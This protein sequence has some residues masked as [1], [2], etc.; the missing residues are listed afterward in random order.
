M[1]SLSGLIL[2]AH[3]RLGLN[4]PDGP[5]WQPRSPQVRSAL[6]ALRDDD[7]ERAVSEI[8]RAWL[9]HPA[10]EAVVARE[11][12]VL[13]LDAEQQHIERRMTDAR[14]LKGTALG[15]I[16]LLELRMKRLR[17][18]YAPRILWI[19]TAAGVLIGGSS[20]VSLLRYGLNPWV[21]GAGAVAFV[22]GA[23]LLLRDD[24]RRQRAAFA[25]RRAQLAAEVAEEIQI[26]HAE[27]RSRE[28]EIETL[29]ATRRR[30]LACQERLPAPI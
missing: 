3:H 4:A 25:G 15:E 8:S 2:A 12:I 10:E 11:V 24:L 28:Q 20:A 1:A 7:L 26:L 6:D 22:A 9:A 16:S 17:F 27:I 13:K 21:G 30:L 18:A 14:K 19:T 29:E 5:D 23:L